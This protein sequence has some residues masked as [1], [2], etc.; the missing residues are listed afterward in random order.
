VNN[1]VRKLL[2][3]RICRDS[4]GEAIGEDDYEHVP[5]CYLNGEL[6]GAQLRRAER[7]AVEQP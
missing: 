5:D 3:M 2:S 6:S 4:N 1:Q 7:A